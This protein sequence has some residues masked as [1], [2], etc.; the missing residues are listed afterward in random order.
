MGTEGAADGMRVS[1][2]QN[3]IDVLIRD[4]KLRIVKFVSGILAI[5]SWF[6][7]GL[8]WT[9]YDCTRPSTYDPGSGRIYRQFT[10]GS[11]VY[12]TAGEH[13]L[14]VWL[15]VAAIVFVIVFLIATAANRFW[16]K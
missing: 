16:P 14:L 1:A 3:E 11:V 6:S 9:Y 2:V 13:Y 7:W 8:A 4:I 12:L 10:H 5:V 15:M